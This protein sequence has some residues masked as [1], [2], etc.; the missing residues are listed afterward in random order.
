[1]ENE[2]KQFDEHDYTDTVKQAAELEP[3]DNEELEAKR[4]EEHRERE[5]MY[6]ALA[7]AA[8]MN[9]TLLGMENNNAA[10]LLQLELAQELMV[11]ERKNTERDENP[12][13]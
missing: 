4:R 9:G 13:D 11:E 5:K 7:I 8:A 2:N 10:G 12:E 3:S 1:M 6:E